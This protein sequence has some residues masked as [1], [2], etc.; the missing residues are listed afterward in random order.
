MRPEKMVQR[1][2][3]SLTCETRFVEIPQTDHSPFI[4]ASLMIG[5][6]FFASDFGGGRDRDA[7]P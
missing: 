6:H 3:V 4:P 2:N 1:S 7:R 5:H